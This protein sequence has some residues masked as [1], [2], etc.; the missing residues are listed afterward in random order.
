M[1][2]SGGFRSWPFRRR[3]WSH[4]T[5]WT[6]GWVRSEHLYT[7]GEKSL[8]PDVTYTCLP[9]KWTR[10]LLVSLFFHLHHT[11]R[12]SFIVFIGLHSIF[13]NR[14]YTAWQVPWLLAVTRYRLIETAVFHITPFFYLPFCRVFRWFGC[15]SY[16]SVFLYSLIVLQNVAMSFLRDPFSFF[17]YNTS[18]CRERGL[19]LLAPELFF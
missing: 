11:L 15:L 2:L 3:E 9:L 6:A 16:L 8:I 7:L 19:N 10:C 1:E 12:F 13:A 14:L 5:P 17:T 18:M 4:S